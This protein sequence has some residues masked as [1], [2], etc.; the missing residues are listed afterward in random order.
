MR[1]GVESEI[2][3]P[4]RRNRS[5]GPFRIG[6]VGRLTT[7]KNVRFLAELS[8]RLV[9]LG[10]RDFEFVVIGQGTDSDWLREHVVNVIL[11]GVLHGI[12]L[13]EAYASMD[14]FV[15][16]STT[17]TFGNV[18]LEALSSGVPAVVT[19]DGGP[20]F[21]VRHGITGYIASNG[22]EFIDHVSGL[23]VDRVTHA[24]M[25]H[26]ARLYAAGIS[27]DSVFED[28]L[29]AYRHCVEVSAASKVRTVS[30][31]VMA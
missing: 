9:A 27:W 21:L 8:H 17:D 18:I 26:A 29:Q 25:C 2:F 19:S 14:L 30:N 23:L 5:S 28:V 15:F 22:S 4:T 12:P 7:E 20:K 16:P 31:R 3:S 11:P 10:H 6:Y 13:A 1:R 24:R